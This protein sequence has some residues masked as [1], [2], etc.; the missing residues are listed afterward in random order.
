M[1]RLRGGDRGV[2]GGN[3]ELK[4]LLRARSALF[5]A[6]RERFHARGFCEAAVPVAQ[7][8]PNLD[9]HVRPLPVTV[10]DL[11]GLS[12]TLW[13]HTSPELSLKKLLARGSGD[14]YF[15]GPVFRDGETTSRHRPEFTMLEWYRVGAGMAEVMADTRE[16][17]A[18]AALAVT[19]SSRVRWGGSVYDLAEGWEEMTVAEAFR[20]HAGAA[21]LGEE[22]MREALRRAGDP[23]PAGA[24][25][26]ELF[27]RLM[28]GWVDPLLGEERPLLLTGWPAFLGTMARPFPGDPETL[29]RFE[30]YVGGLELANGYAESSDPVEVGRR[31]EEA[32]LILEGEGAEGLTV[33]G[34]FLACL[35]RMPACAGVSVGVDRLLML[36]LGEEEIG[37]VMP[38]EP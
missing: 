13:L 9:P 28:V 27:F 22:A 17:C 25:R 11:D 26:E 19:G 21:D 2:G 20:R 29:C 38:L 15:L 31:M 1:S 7:P 35:P 23:A 34:G 18:E 37:K 4:A 12:R 5:R 8:H 30:A 36:L 6:L 3:L 16:I 14:V 32:R 10:R 33:D 24:S